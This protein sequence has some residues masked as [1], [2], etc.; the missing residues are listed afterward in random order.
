[1]VKHKMRNNGQIAVH[2]KALCVHP[3]PGLMAASVW[4]TLVMGLRR[5]PISRPSPETTPRVKLRSSPKGLPSAY[6][7][8]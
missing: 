8:V 1:M 2:H 5:D 7:Y 3:L 6:T 4:I